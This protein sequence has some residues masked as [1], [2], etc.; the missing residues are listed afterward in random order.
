MHEVMS[1][2]FLWR[3]SK[4]LCTLVNKC[5]EFGE[6]MVVVM[7]SFSLL[8]ESQKGMAGLNCPS[9]LQKICSWKGMKHPSVYKM[10]L[11]QKSNWEYLF[12]SLWKDCS[13]ETKL[14]CL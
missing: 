13:R 7:D 5:E 11:F 2:N 4:S 14:L 3:C 8:L 1:G 12:V 9:V 6:H 10:Y